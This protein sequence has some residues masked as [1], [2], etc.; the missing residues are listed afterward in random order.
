[1]HKTSLIK[2]FLRYA[3]LWCKLS[4][5]NL[6]NV[7]LSG[8]DLHGLDLSWYNMSSVNLC[9]ANLRHADLNFTNL[10]GA[11]LN[12]ADLTNAVLF[13]ANL[14]CADLCNAILDNADLRNANLHK[15][16][17]INASIKNVRWN[18]CTIGLA[19]APEGELIGWCIEN[20][21][22]IKLLIPADSPRSCDT[23]RKFRAAW[24]RVL[25]IDDGVFDRIE[26]K[27]GQ[28]HMIYE[29]GKITKADDWD[30]NRWNSC[31][32][33]IYFFLSRA[34]AEEWQRNTCNF[35][36]SAGDLRRWRK[37]DAIWLGK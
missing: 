20:N 7:D 35:V 33:G 13:G 19:P 15:A 32:H 27:C 5:R 24:V 16:C 14:V 21:H 3:S 29:V 12:G 31:S 22:L 8:Q 1:M 17:L 25:E 37:Y 4:K 36:P 34:E 6:V 10:E 26:C 11:K 23:T 28:T 9:N 30:E 18:Y 2:K